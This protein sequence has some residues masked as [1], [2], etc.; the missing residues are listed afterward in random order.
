M[1]TRFILRFDDITPRMAWSKFLP[2]KEILEKNKIKSLLGVVPESQD[3]KL[4]VEKE[5]GDFFDM[6]RFWER[7]GDSIAQHGLHHC[8]D[9]NS[10]GILAINPRSEFAGLSYDRQLHRI[11]KGKELLEREGVWH[12]FFMAPAHSFDYKTLKALSYF[13][14]KAVTDGY[15]FHPYYMNSILLVPQ[16]TSFPLHAGFGVCTICVHINSMKDIDIRKLQNFIIFN[17]NKFVDF[18]DVVATGGYD[19]FFSRMIRV[20]SSTFLKSYRKIR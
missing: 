16:M 10:A 20:T 7:Y 15:G 12:P 14:F 18:K 1:S 2:F 3:P 5:R 11:R 13:N 4:D 9:S 19:D 8:Y 17:K 6:V